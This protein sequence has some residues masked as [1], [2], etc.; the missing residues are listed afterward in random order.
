MAVKSIVGARRTARRIP[1]GP[2]EGGWDPRQ[3]AFPMDPP[4]PGGYPQPRRMP[5]DPSA[6]EGSASGSGGDDSGAIFRLLR[7]HEEFAGR[8]GGTVNLNYDYTQ[9]VSQWTEVA[10]MMRERPERCVI[11]ST[12][13]NFGNLAD[14]FVTIGKV[15]PPRV[16]LRI[17]VGSGGNSGSAQA[18]MIVPAGVPVAVTGDHIYVDTAMFEDE[19]GTVPINTT[20]F[21]AANGFTDIVAG[22]SATNVLS[23]QVSAFIAPGD[24][25][26]TA[27]PTAWFQPGGPEATTWELVAANVWQGPGR[28]KQALGYAP[29]SNAATDYLMFFDWPNLSDSIVLP[30]PAAAQPLIEIPLPAGDPF[31]LDF[32]VSTKVVS[33]GLYWAVSSTSGSFTQSTDKAAVWVERYSDLQ[34]DNNSSLIFL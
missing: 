20:I 26:I 5:L 10:R 28:L 11:Y 2:F 8:A 25:T 12:Y 4:L 16:L 22:D 3:P 21:T 34:L 33:Q 29:S 19:W 32:S 7:R 23:T 1:S 30:V 13:K 18:I 6:D 17:R 24:P 9:G 15:I 27:Q 14:G 31:S